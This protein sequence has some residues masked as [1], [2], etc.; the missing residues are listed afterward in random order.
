RWTQER[1]CELSETESALLRFLVAHRQ[2]AVARDEILTRL[3]GITPQHLETR[4]IDM[5]IARLRT[6]RRDPSRPN[7]PEAPLPVRSQG[8]MAAPD[9][10]PVEAAKNGKH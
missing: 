4:T 2:R 10:L 6:K 1:R 9:L 8:Y 7:T 3:W 5:R